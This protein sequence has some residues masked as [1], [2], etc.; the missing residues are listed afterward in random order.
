MAKAKGTIDTRLDIC[1]AKLSKP[2]QRAIIEHKI[3]T[4][5]DL[6]GWERK[7]LAKAHGI[8]PSSFPV[9]EHALNGAG[10]RFKGE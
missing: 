5:R 10:L 4:P 8:G 2:A 9:F 6:S 1:F 3:F 7:E